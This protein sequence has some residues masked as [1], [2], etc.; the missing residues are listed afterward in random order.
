VKE[1][2]DPLLQLGGV[3]GLTH[4]NRVVEEIPLNLRRQIIPVHDHCGA[5]SSQNMLLL[6]GQ[7]GTRLGVVL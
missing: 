6:L 7:G 2:R 1:A 4:G 5:E 3:T